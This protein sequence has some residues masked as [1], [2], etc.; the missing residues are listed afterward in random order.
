MAQA[1]RSIEV[2]VDP[3]TF[4]NVISDFEKY[5]EFLKELRSIRI[6]KSG[7]NEWT[8]TFFVTI[9]KNIE[10]TLDFKGTPG[11]GLEWTLA[12]KGFM[13]KNS[14]SWALEEIDENQTKAT[15]ATEIDLGLLAPKSIVNMLISTNFP[16]MLKAFKEQA[17]SL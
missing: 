6:D 8:V 1:S 2:N 13:K 5:P 3:M 12:K 9:V 16:T 4:Y 7:E 10:Y 15:Y 11:K 14:G 17:E